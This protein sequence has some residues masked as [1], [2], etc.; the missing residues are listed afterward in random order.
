MKRALDK[1]RQIADQVHEIH[2]T[3]TAAGKLGRFS[4]DDIEDM[5]DLEEDIDD[6]IDDSVRDVPKCPIAEQPKGQIGSNCPRPNPAT[7]SEYL[8]SQ[9]LKVDFGYV[10]RLSGTRY[11]AEILDYHNAL[12]A[13]FGS[14]KLQWNPALAAHAGD[15]AK[16]MTETGQLAHSPR[17]GREGERENL[18]LGL[19][20]ANSIQKMLDGWGSERR[21]YTPGIFPNVSTTGDWMRVAHFTQM[22][23]PTTTQIGC[24]F[25]ARRKYDA[26]VC[27]Y[28]P[29][30]N[31]DGRPL[32]PSNPCFPVPP[33]P[34]PPPPGD[35]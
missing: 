35:D 22:V 4:R 16:T 27:R 18:S 23:W 17:T 8:L 1:L 19:H 15:Y 5:I 3:A 29:P 33:P 6:F 12:R 32:M 28:S 30:G 21:F 26:L 11:S 31:T 10:P 7:P 34:P 24:G 25:Y 20:R 14:P 2:E 13:E 9:P